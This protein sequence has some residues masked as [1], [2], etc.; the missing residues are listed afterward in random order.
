[1]D[2]VLPVVG[3]DGR[4]SYKK[5]TIEDPDFLRLSDI[6]DED[7]C[8]RYNID[9]SEIVS[10]L[11]PESTLVVLIY[12]DQ[13]AVACGCI[14]RIE[15]PS[16]V[17]AAISETS[18]MHGTTAF[19]VGRVFVCPAH[20]GKAR[21]NVVVYLM[22]RLEQEAKLRGGYLIVVKTGERQPEAMKIYQRGGYRTVPVFGKP[23]K[24]GATNALGKVLD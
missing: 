6:L 1:M 17:A 19:E 10:S 24:T 4:L 3:R 18:I 12:S 21:G 20:R 9:R 8:V 23:F 2:S 11:D 13:E 16:Y 15:L 14:V 5:T 22:Q 7:L